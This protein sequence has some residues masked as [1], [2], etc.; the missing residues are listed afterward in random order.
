MKAHQN[1]ALLAVQAAEQAS[2]RL[3][4]YSSCASR[5]RFVSR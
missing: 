2:M 4:H 3:V 5:F 1:S